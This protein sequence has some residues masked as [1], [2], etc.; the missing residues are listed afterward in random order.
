M[1][2]ILYLWP[3]SIN[4][5]RPT[6]NG[7]HFPD[8]IFK[9]IFLNENV[10]FHG[11][12]FLWFQLTIFQ[13][14]FRYWLGANQA[15]SHYLS[16]WWLTYRRI[17]AS[18]GLNAPLSNLSWPYTNLSVNYDIG[19]ENA[20]LNI[21]LSCLLLTKFNGYSVK[22]KMLLLLM[23][24]EMAAEFTIWN[25]MTIFGPER[26]ELTLYPLVVI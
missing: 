4:T 25:F 7:H 21:V 11:S 20:K 18:L 8:N 14:W 24:Q 3:L 5:L 12:F 13:H 19:I 17:F 26:E 10:W 9:C 1:C 16:Q 22:I 23:L 15:T 2:D 6:Q